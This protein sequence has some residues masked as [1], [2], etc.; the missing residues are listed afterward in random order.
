MLPPLPLYPVLEISFVEPCVRISRER[1]ATCWNTA[2]MALNT[3]V[4]V[5]HC[6][7]TLVIPIASSLLPTTRGFESCWDAM[8][9][10][11]MTLLMDFAKQK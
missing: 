1:L 6:K 2:A 7:P 5:A 11:D 3:V 8:L 10:R 4:L 9:D